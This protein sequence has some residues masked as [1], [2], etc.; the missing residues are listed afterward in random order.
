ML[1]DHEWQYHFWRVGAIVDEQFGREE[2][3]QR[4]PRYVRGVPL[5]KRE[6]WG[7]T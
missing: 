3:R 6:L 4:E 5:E 2:R 1:A 7:T